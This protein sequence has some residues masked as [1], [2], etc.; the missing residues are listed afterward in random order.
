MGCGILD[1][2]LFFFLYIFS[3]KQSGQCLPYF[4][5]PLQCFDVCLPQDISGNPEGGINR[6]LKSAGDGRHLDGGVTLKSLTKS[7]TAGIHL[8]GSFIIQAERDQ[9][10]FIIRRLIIITCRGRS[11]GTASGSRGNGRV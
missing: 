9:R 6:Y 7:D 1:F 4:Y 5:L 2:R 10:P 8:L 11:G 3:L